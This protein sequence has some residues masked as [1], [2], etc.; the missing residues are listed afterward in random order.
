MRVYKSNNKISVHAVAGTHVVI[1]G[2]NVAEDEKTG[3]LG[4]TILKKSQ[5][6]KFTP[7][8]GGNRTFENYDD[9]VLP[10]SENY[11]IQSMLWSDYAAEP[12]VKYT[13]KVIPIYGTTGNMKKGVSVEIKVTTEN[14]EDN[15]HAIFFNRGVAGSQAYTE[16]FGR[17]LKYYPVKTGYGHKQ[18]IKPKAFIKP[19]DV[20]R[21]AAYKWL[22]RG[23]EEGMLDFIKQAEGSEYSVRAAVYEFTYEPAI[24]AF[25]DVLDSGADVKI[26]YHSKLKSNFLLKSAPRGSDVSTVT[27]WVEP[28]QPS[29]TFKKKYALSERK[30]DN[31]AAAALASVRPLGVKN[32]K[33]FEALQN[34]LIPRCNTT[35][36]HNKFIVLLKDD[37]PIQVWTGSTNFTEGGIFGQSNVG[38]VVRDKDV[39]ANYFA[40]W[41][42][43]AHDPKSKKM[44]DWTVGQQDDL[45]SKPK[46]GITPIFSPRASDDM[47]QWYADRMAEAKSSIFFTAAFSVAKEFV[48]VATKNKRLKKQ[49]AY[50]RYL[51]LEGNG[52]LMKDK[53]PL[54]Q[55]CKHNKVAWGDVLRKRK[56]TLGNSPVI[57]ILTGL[58]SHVNFLHTKYMLID[59][60]SEDPIVISGSAN[61]STASTVRNDENMLIIRGNK[62]VADIFL[63]EFMRLFN[64][65]DSRNERNK[66]TDVEFKKKSFLTADDS[67]TNPYFVHGSHAWNERLLFA[68]P[69]RLD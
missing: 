25:I 34:M 37:V 8:R 56:I 13:Y 52:G 67:W 5:G 69:K 27:T 62:R 43:L 26:I 58:N 15:K 65:F 64:H 36:S 17:Y 32:L 33:R 46:L 10:N 23:L 9:E 51:L 12:G 47:L 63:T 60:L 11:P 16:R 53:V 24:Q 28:S 1:L 61:F 30:P 42:E 35:I 40:Y 14:V 49:V 54:L 41:K 44:R 3:L 68:G 18:K 21:R 22:S 39:A 55:A 6:K 7:L 31:Q 38:H 50:Q 59:P 2:L 57:E 66:M 20:P 4:F 48:E 45:K 19:K 29:Q